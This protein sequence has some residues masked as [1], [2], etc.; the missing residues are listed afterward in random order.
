MSNLCGHEHFCVN[1]GQPYL[2]DHP[3]C[4]TLPGLQGACQ[5]CSYLYGWRQKQEEAFNDWSAL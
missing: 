4:M 2:C 1:C 5:R 3:E